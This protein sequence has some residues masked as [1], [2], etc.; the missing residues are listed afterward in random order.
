MNHFFDR[1]FNPLQKLSGNLNDSFKGGQNQRHHC[2]SWRQINMN[3]GG[4]LSLRGILEKLKLVKLVAVA[5]NASGKRDNMSRSYPQPLLRSATHACN[6]E[7][8][9]VLANRR[10]RIG[11]WRLSARRTRSG[12]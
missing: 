7:D 11:Q 3:R 12:N 5:N 6:F 8:Y 4:V 10:N 9:S 1:R 2:D